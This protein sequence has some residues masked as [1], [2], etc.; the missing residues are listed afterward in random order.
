MNAHWRIFNILNLICLTL[1]TSFV[2]WPIFERPPLDL[3]HHKLFYLINLLVLL[4]VVVNC[5]HNI[6]LTGI[7]ASERYFTLIRKIFFW[8]LYTLF[9]AVILVIVYFIPDV[10]LYYFREKGTLLE[11]FNLRQVVQMLSILATGLYI[12]VMQI[13]LFFKIKRSYRR[14]LNNSVDEIGN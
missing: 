6:I 13:I 1:Y 3:L 4:I 10:L 9:T 12:I 7:L 2:V 14:G 8:I 5:I 11:S